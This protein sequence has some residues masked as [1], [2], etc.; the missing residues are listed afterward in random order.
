MKRILIILAPLLLLCIGAVSVTQVFAHAAYDH[1]TPARD[2]V[3]QTPPAK[4][5]IFFKEDVVKVSGQYFVHVFNDQNAQVSTPAD[6][7]VDDDDRTHMFADLPASL[8]NGRYIVRW[9]NV[10]FDDGDAE[11]GAFCFYVGVQPTAAQQTECA[12]FAEEEPTAA[13][14]AVSSP[15]ASATPVATASETPQPSPTVAASSNDD[16]GANTGLIIGGVIGGAVVLAIVGGA[17][18]IWLRRTLA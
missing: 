8:S 15:E 10:S 14:T 5:D 4:V 7:T 3:V 6:G 1:S 13:A 11:E 2:E 18:V 12:A 17:V 16:G 9:S